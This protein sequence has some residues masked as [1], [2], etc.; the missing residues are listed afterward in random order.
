MRQRR[1]SGAVAGDAK[2]GYKRPKGPAPLGGLLAAAWI[3]LAG[4]TVPALALPVWDLAWGVPGAG[5]VAAGPTAA[6]AGP[7]VGGG[8]PQTLPPSERF[9]AEVP[10]SGEAPGPVEPSAPAEVPL[11]GGGALPGE[12]PLA[13]E[14]P[15]PSQ[16]SPGAASAPSMPR[17]PRQ[18]PVRVSLFE[19]DIRD[20]ISELAIQ[21]KVNILLTPEVRGSVTAELEDVPLETALEILTAPFGY[22]FRWTGSYYLVGVPDPRSLSF[23]NL[24]E[25]AVIPV[26]YDDAARILELLSDYFRP[27]VK[28]DAAGRR[29]LVTGP[30]SIVE[31]I[32]QQ[33]ARLDRPPAE[34]Q[35][36]VVVTELTERASQELGVTDVAYRQTDNRPLSVTV[37]PSGLDV[38]YAQF[39]SKLRLLE[40]RREARIRADPDVRVSE[41]RT[42]SLFA[43]QREFFVITA[44]Q[45]TPR[46][47]PVES[48]VKLNLTARVLRPGE[49]LVSVSP[50]VSQVL[51]DSRVVPALESNEVST[52]VRLLSGQTAVL[53]AMSIDRAVSG[54]Q[55]TPG[56]GDLPLIGWLFRRED[57]EESRRRLVIFITPEV[58]PEP[59][60]RLP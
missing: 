42:F 51:R 7:S 13:P 12:L 57:R 14:A 58:L 4:A 18:V 60:A 2:G 27:Y 37:S 20:A 29:L 33:V 56:L 28:A 53:A 39:L 6:D 26:V 5:R 25:T 21:A 34:L 30:A 24:A 15:I 41:G 52:T 17:D 59:V 11:T 50:S 48:G 40:E 46:V 23:G 55:Q 43:G 54:E 16:P 31:R 22:A 36:R 1:E 9:Q 45:V 38:N 10:L 3:G 47:E 19:T 44:E 49:L 35:V 8:P 32:R